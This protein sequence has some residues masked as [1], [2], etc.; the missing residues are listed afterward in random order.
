ME[1][2]TPQNLKPVR[3]N[4]LSS[5]P[6][7][8]NSAGSL[9]RQLQPSQPSKP[10]Q[11]P[12]P[13]QQQ[14]QAK[15]PQAIQK[16]AELPTLPN[17]SQ[18]IANKKSPATAPLLQSSKIIMPPQQGTRP[19]QLPTNNINTATN[20]SPMTTTIQ[21]AAQ[22]ATTTT[23]TNNNNNNNQPVKQ[24]VKPITQAPYMKQPVRHHPIAP[25]YTKI[26]P[27]IA[28]KPKPIAIAP[29]SSSLFNPIPTGKCSLLI[30]LTLHIQG[31][32][33]N[34]LN[35]SKRWVL[36]P[37]PR[38]GRKPTAGEC[39]KVIKTPAN[40]VKRKPKSL[41][42][43]GGGTG[44]PS[45]ATNNSN[46]AA[47]T[48][49]A[50]TNASNA[51]NRTSL[52]INSQP[53]KTVQ[54]MRQTNSPVIN[55]THSTHN[56][57]TYTPLKQPS[58]PI[59]NNS[60]NNDNNNNN[61]N[62]SKN[63]IINNNNSNINNNNII[64]NNSNSNINNN[65]NKININDNKKNINI[66][67]EPSAVKKETSVTGN[68]PSLTTQENNCKPV[69][70]LLPSL[71]TTLR[72]QTLPRKSNQ[73]SPTPNTTTTNKTTKTT[74]NMS[75][76]TTHQKASLQLQTPNTATVAPVPATTTT[77]TTTTAM[78]PNTLRNVDGQKASQNELSSPKLSSPLFSN[79]TNLN[80]SQTVQTPVK[81]LPTP[82]PPSK[83]ID[84]ATQ[85][86][87][88][89]MS[90][91]SKLKEQ[92]L[93]RNYIEVLTNQIKELSF[94]QNGVITFD[95]L[96]TTAK[97]SPASTMTSKR[98]TST[99]TN[100][101]IDQLDS[102][103]N[104]NDLN[105]FLSYL[106]KS[107][108]IIKNAQRHP[109]P[110]NAGANSNANANQ[111]RNADGNSN[112]NV[113]VNGSTVTSTAGT[114]IG[115]GLSKS[116]SMI[117]TSES[118]NHQID[119]YLDLRN[120]FKV[121]NTQRVKA[122]APRKKNKSPQ[123]GYDQSLPATS[124]KLSTSTAQPNASSSTT[125]AI[126]TLSLKAGD[127]LSFS[128]KSALKIVAAQP[129]PVHATAAAAN[130][131]GI[132]G[133]TNNASAHFT[134][135]LLHPL[136]ASK[137]FN[138]S[139]NDYDMLELQTATIAE[140]P[141]S[142]KQ[143]GSGSK[144][145]DSVNTSMI[146]L[147]VLSSLQNMDIDLFVDENEFLNRLVLDDVNESSNGEIDENGVNGVNGGTG[148]GSNG[149]NDYEVSLKREEMELGKV[150]IHNDKDGRLAEGGET[151]SSLNSKLQVEI[152]QENT[153][154]DGRGFE[155]NS[156]EAI[157][158]KKFKFNCGF[159]TKDTPCL[160]FDSDWELQGMK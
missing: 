131:T 25:K 5:E 144:S 152:K 50:A 118:I 69:T 87:G 73:L 78:I 6:S 96:R 95:A 100:S 2:S 147:E 116:P 106:G 9:S 104:L 141:A 113:N 28:P 39:D 46:V 27:A 45:L 114:N 72:T 84:P 18:F 3:S 124:T 34:S 32:D 10:S 151:Q 91:L 111:Y 158:R 154:V 29:L 33:S 97:M 53:Q 49:A 26:Q 102:I 68:I 65:N 42:T 67:I 58:N 155:I 148:D 52:S 30:K 117:N 59:I 90:Y 160:C 157:M 110:A 38:P 85:M 112:V 132:E 137:L 54:E 82:P 128:D 83:A 70:S 107:S 125:N 115:S 120:R 129:V 143:S 136:K 14:Q 43:N 31:T 74:P 135:D 126:N 71:D 145:N 21:N 122:N 105:K 40:T 11:P 150:D 94:V 4:G 55:K 61:N 63:L 109:S 19:L 119:Y 44:V 76:Q 15:Q 79:K 133:N 56:N 23:T 35:T 37:R 146:T 64:I 51:I 16:L 1:S 20:R 80:T 13:L 75:A 99:L 138:D 153:N 134:P 123:Q 7:N 159:C 92:E 130:T 57:K 41:G 156:S 93:M 108:D 149:L 98:L 60:N 62:K 81:K 103:N 66:P 127:K 139:Q 48:P 24:A 89:K 140:S 8:D 88:L 142:M 17:A 101:K 121:L 77:T 86:M 22:A 47:T 36:P 12:H